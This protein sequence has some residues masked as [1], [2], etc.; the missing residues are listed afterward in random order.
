VALVCPIVVVVAD[1]AA[2][3][4]TVSASAAH[5]NNINRFT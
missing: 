1:D 2:V 4:P 5:R 3:T